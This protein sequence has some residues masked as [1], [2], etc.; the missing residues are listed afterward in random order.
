MQGY[1]KELFCLVFFHE[2]LRIAQKNLEFLKTE[3]SS[4]NPYRQGILLQVQLSLKKV[5]KY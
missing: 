2:N 5:S 3:M 1:M 4:V